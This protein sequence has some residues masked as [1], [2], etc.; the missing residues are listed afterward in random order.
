MLGTGKHRTRR[1]CLVLEVNDNG[2][3]P[4]IHSNKYKV[5]EMEANGE[6]F[7]DGRK[8]SWPTMRG[9]TG[10]GQPP[11]ALSKL[12]SLTLFKAHMFAVPDLF[13]DVLHRVRLFNLAPVLEEECH[14]NLIAR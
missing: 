4:C 12:A 9:H 11:C 8:S 14:L 2:W 1:C 6:A 10:M 3:G 7:Y 5:M 13:P